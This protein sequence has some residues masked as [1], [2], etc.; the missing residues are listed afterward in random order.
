MFRHFDVGSPPQLRMR[1]SWIVSDTFRATFRAR[2]TV[3][4]RVTLRAGR[5]ARVCAAGIALAACHRAPPPAAPRPRP[6]PSVQV[7]A[8]ANPSRDGVLGSHPRL[9]RADRDLNGDGVPE[10]IVVDRSLC[11]AEGNC[12]WNVFVVPPTGSPDCARYVGT[13]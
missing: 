4:H 8:C 10:A 13:F 6:A 3:R 12:Y 11:T 9:D 1:R 7:G 2:F 5:W